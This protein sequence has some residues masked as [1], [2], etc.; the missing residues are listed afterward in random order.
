MK[1]EIERREQE[2][3]RSPK[4]DFIAG[5][6]QPAIALP[7]QKASTLIPGKNLV[8]IAL[9]ICVGVILSDNFSMNFVFFVYLLLL[10]DGWWNVGVPPVA[11]GALQ[12]ASVAV[13]S[14]PKDGRQNKKSKW[15]KVDTDVKNPSLPGQDAM[16]TVGVHAAMLSAANAGAGYTAFAQQKRREAE[17]KKSSERKFDKRS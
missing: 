11:A 10:F 14:V 12:S 8:L 4:V 3:K 15:D 5:G 2:R 13:D 6:T 17:E 9:S 16:S 7:A 1:R